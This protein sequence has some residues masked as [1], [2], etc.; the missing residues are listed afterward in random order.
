M[1]A[2]TPPSEQMDV[3][4][5]ADQLMRRCLSEVDRLHAQISAD[6]DEIKLLREGV[7]NNLIAVEK[8]ARGHVGVFVPY[9]LGE[10]LR[11]DIKHA[12]TGFVP[13]LPEELE[14]SPGDPPSS[15]DAA[16]AEWEE[17]ADTA[18][19]DTRELVVAKRRWDSR[20]FKRMKSRPPITTDLWEATE[21]LSTIHRALPAL[22]EQYVADHLDSK[23]HL[24]SDLAAEIE[25]RQVAL[26]ASFAEARETLVE[27]ELEAG[28]TSGDWADP[29]WLDPVPATSLQRVIRAGRLSPALPASSGI[30]DIPVL[31]QHPPATGIAIAADVTRR[32]EA[33]DCARSLAMRILAATP[34]GG[35]H[36]SFVDPV[37]LGQSASAFRHLA[38]FD[39]RLVDIKSWTSERE[40]E[41]KLD[42]LAAHLEVVISTYLR[43]QF[44]SID[45]YNE[46]AGEIAEPHRVLVVF[47]FPTGFSSQAAR[48]LLSLIENGTR[49]GVHVILHHDP[50]AGSVEGVELHR[51]THSMLRLDLTSG[52]GQVT[53]PEPI[54]AI[55]AD[56]VP[57]QLPPIEF[58]AEGRPETP[59][60][61]LLL[62]IG[63]ASRSSQSGPVTLERVVPILN[64]LTVAKVSQQAPILRHGAVEIDLAD[65]MTWWNAET[66]AAACAPIGRSGAN[67][68]ASLYFS[69]TEIAGGAIVIGL[70]RSGKST[71]LHAAIVSLALLYPPEELELYL[72]D[73]KHGVEFKAYDQL[74]HARIVSINSE[75]EFSVNALQSLDGE[76][77]R[78]AELMKQETA[79]KA[80]ITEY[81][82]ATGKAMPRIV[83]FMDEFHELF[84]EDDA[85]GQAAFQAFS[86]IVRQG[87]FAG[88]HLVVA[89]QTLSSMPAMDRGTLSL[90]PMRVAFMCNESD[91]DLVMGD[92]NRDIRGLSRQGEGIFNPARGEASHNKPFRGTYI[93]PDERAAL[94]TE[95]G[96]KASEEGVDRRPRVFDGDRPA[97]RPTEAPD[98]SATRPVFAL[99]EPFDLDPFAGVTLRRGRG[100]NV[101]LLG[102][103]AEDQAIAAAAQSCIADAVASEMAVEVLDF[104]GDSDAGKG[105]DLLGLCE[106]L[107]VRYQ[108]SSGLQ[109]CLEEVLAVVSARQ[110]AA[111]YRQPGL[112]LMLNGIHRAFDLKPD[113]SYDDPPGPGALLARILREGPEVGCHTVALAES[114]AQFEGKLGRDLLDEFGWCVFGSGAPRA[115][116]AALTDNYNAPEIRN[117]Q[118][119]I[120]DR[121]TAKQ[122]R[123]RAYSRYSQDS[124]SPSTIGAA[125]E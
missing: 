101:L 18:G 116:L 12:F 36:L 69:S 66:A 84:E 49:C 90:L 20:I 95:V 79:G 125:D 89:S 109:A 102:T 8:E 104:V 44:D 62:R 52:K 80:N 43:G 35:V 119:L 41:A 115:D 77:Q 83:M 59:V 91:A 55:D 67:D 32:Q 14:G 108:G 38:E 23:S 29:R 5:K 45:A 123:I 112:L 19:K 1:A 13:P 56:F 107:S 48:Q 78:R 118:L 85:L 74:P 96:R 73:S 76:I 94:L 10:S 46:H 53:L 106:A 110:D 64:K 26:A 97:A 25:R 47:D 122:R 87:P 37:S 86:N 63:A 28:L 72:L 117:S 111:D 17:V 39:Q 70:P 30:T 9:D 21:R 88:V 24:N 100:A 33:I 61:E 40:I 15:F 68:L 51:L 65:P 60:A 124:F 16:R 34:S 31:L 4:G 42:E 98:R 57:D 114:L 120:A 92:L 2:M 93:P 11:S 7:R 71:A 75:R 105:L 99:G 54:G 58:S 113:D 6:A 3:D 103:E 50:A 121:P 22:R 82:A 81:R 27:I